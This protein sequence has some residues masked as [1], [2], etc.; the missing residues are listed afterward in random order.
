MKNKTTHNPTQMIKCTF[1]NAVHKILE[2]NIGVKRSQRWKKEYQEKYK[3]TDEQ[4]IK[5]FDEILKIHNESSLELINYRRSRSIKKWVQKEREAR[6][7][8]PKKKTPLK[9]D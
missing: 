5:M 1:S 7:Y 6:G 2:P 4:K 3:L 9:A 8:V